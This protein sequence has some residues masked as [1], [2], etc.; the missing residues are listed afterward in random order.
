MTTIFLECPPP[1]IA[2]RPLTED[3]AVAIWI[4]RWFKIRPKDLVCRYSCD[5][6]RLYEIWEES[7]FPGSRA[8]AL[9]LMTERYPSLTSRIDP[10]LHQRISKAADPRQL[11]LFG[12]PADAR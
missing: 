3:D 6:R 8:K 2:R 11:T 9:A 1:V 4:A 7:R 5:P 12:E 10:G